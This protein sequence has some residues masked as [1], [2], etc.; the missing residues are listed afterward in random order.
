MT[1]IQKALRAALILSLQGH[2]KNDHELSEIL[3]AIAND[4]HELKTLQSAQNELE[5]T[6]QAE[7]ASL[8][9]RLATSLVYISEDVNEAKTEYQALRE[10]TATGVSSLMATLGSE[11]QAF[12]K[13][14]TD[15]LNN[16]LILDSER[17]ERVRLDWVHYLDGSLN[18]LKEFPKLYQ[19]EESLLLGFQ[20]SIHSA[21][22]QFSTILQ[23]SREE[24]DSY[25]AVIKQQNNT[26]A[27]LE[28]SMTQ[29]ANSLHAQNNTIETLSKRLSECERLQGSVKELSGLAERFEA[30]VSK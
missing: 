16:E 28:N 27:T 10:I 9:K 30:L 25:R 5:N 6:L 4:S 21:T 13:I 24:M 11:I 22:G 8:Q 14:F 2:K 3:D 23:E 15:R 7:L 20:E 12:K 18:K 19:E 17:W 1:E 26:I 29:L